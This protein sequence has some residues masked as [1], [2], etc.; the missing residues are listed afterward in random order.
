MS[1]RVVVVVPGAEGGWIVRALA[2]E[3]IAAVRAEAD[4]P[5]EA[6]I[7]ILDREVSPVEPWLERLA[8]D[9][10]LVG[11][12]P[13]EGDEPETIASVAFYSRPVNVPGLI[14][15]LQTLMGGEPLPA[16][17]KNSS[18]PPPSGVHT[19]ASELDAGATLHDDA[20]A[21]LRLH[22]EAGQDAADDELADDDGDDAGP[23][24]EAADDDGDDAPAGSSAPP[25]TSVRPARAS[26]APSAS[27]G[28]TLH[29]EPVF[30]EAED[31]AEA[32]EP[33]EAEKPAPEAAKR[34]GSSSV[35]AT[36]EVDERSERRAMAP[37][38]TLGA[39]PGDDI[40]IPPMPPAP[41]EP[42]V[43]LDTSTGALLGPDD[44]EPLDDEPVA[45]AESEAPPTPDPR[46]GRTLLSPRLAGLLGDADRRLFPNE[47]PLE[48]SF[49]VGDETPDVLVPD[50]LLAESSTPLEPREAD[51]LEAF[52]FVGTP[53]L[54]ET[55]SGAK[56][57]ASESS[58]SVDLTP[59]TV[60]ER[61]SKPPPGTSERPPG[62]TSGGYAGGSSAGS[63]DLT[64]AGTVPAGGALRMVLELVQ[65]RRACRVRLEVP[66]GL[67]V[68]LHLDGP[69]LLGF[70]GPAATRAMDALVA[71]GRLAPS[72]TALDDDGAAAYLDDAVEAGEILAL[73][74]DRARRVA[75][76]T[77]LGQVLFAEEARYAVASAE[78]APAAE[79][80]L[81]GSLP[82]VLLELARR[83]VDGATLARWLRLG[84]G[85]RL[86]I[87]EGFTR[88]S[89]LLAPRRLGLEPEL[90]RAILDAAGEPLAALL[91]APAEY[92]VPGV[93]FVLVSAGLVEVEGAATD[94][95]PEPVRPEVLRA[96]IERA[97]ALA[98]EGT[99]HAILGVS[100]GTA[101]RRLAVAREQLRESL[102]GNL[103][104]LGLG[105]LEPAR[106]LALAAIDEAFEVL[107][108]PRW[109]EL[110]EGRGVAASPQPAG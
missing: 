78:A 14:R 16:T 94:A 101:P 108:H 37:L 51:P 49:P 65:R 103:E 32:E 50:D 33:A 25:A 30:G 42:T 63:V 48:L 76:E 17:P 28:A 71:A 1:E 9:L 110:Y 8:G 70:R 99:Y 89:G 97:R 27:A 102:A 73:E 60:V 84:P 15:R 38:P 36:L 106:T 26:R 79:T 20:P 95:G 3:G 64:R 47:A 24:E 82:A 22:G 53:D 2:R 83:L 7:L 105:G 29:D 96:A 92:G 98:E 66:G 41:R 68:E 81:A 61:A 80:D 62:T 11:W 58:A 6:S 21:L 93:L 54:L 85:H 90:V 91:N 109:G 86:A 88:E 107:S 4:E 35:P 19:A 31:P 18:A 75:V 104:W 77:M 44:D 59:H 52:T 43:R 56:V 39:P 87:G 13:P 100:P 46:A 67:D 69:R 34:S 57:A 23:A 55:A 40:E 45:A 74:R 10:V 72:A 12:D 5:R